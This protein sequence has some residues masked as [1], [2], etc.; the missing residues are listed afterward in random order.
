MHVI[1]I[2]AVEL[3]TVLDVVMVPANAKLGRLVTQMAKH[4]PWM[5]VS[6]GAPSR[7]RQ[8]ACGRLL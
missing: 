7:R 1:A 6:P 3:A 2:L 8:D 4:P 5:P